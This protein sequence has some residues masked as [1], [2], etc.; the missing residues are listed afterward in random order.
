MAVREFSDKN[1]V[2]W[3][4]WQTRPSRDIYLGKYREG[5]LTFEC[6]GE[7]RR[8]APVPAAWEDLPVTRL[9]LMCRAAETT[10]TLLG[11]GD[12]WAEASSERTI[13]SPG[14]NA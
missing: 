5:W 2:L 1:G 7:R 12:G 4:V 9:E 13:D 6:D 3:R 14:E 11:I 10:E 8:L